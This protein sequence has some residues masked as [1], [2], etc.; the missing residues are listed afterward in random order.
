MNLNRGRAT[1][2]GKR[3]TK[4]ELRTVE[5][6]WPIP[7]GQPAR[8]LHLT[9]L[10]GG[11]SAVQYKNPGPPLPATPPVVLFLLVINEVRGLPK[12]E[13]TKPL[14]RVQPQRRSLGSLG[15]HPYLSKYPHYILPEPR[16]PVYAS[17]IE[18][19]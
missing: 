12:S 18:S 19:T 10:G 3:L 4:Q 6:T 15:G 13:P 8:K 9:E 16:Y 17:T 1:K 11:G 7:L 2:K 14:S 5:R